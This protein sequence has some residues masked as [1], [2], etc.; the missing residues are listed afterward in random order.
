[1]ER[2]EQT[3]P[4]CNPIYVWS[5]QLILIQTAHQ[6]NWMRQSTK[7]VHSTMVLTMVYFPMLVLPIHSVSLQRCFHVRNIIYLLFGMY[8]INESWNMLWYIIVYT[9]KRRIVLM[10][11]FIPLKSFGGYCACCRHVFIQNKYY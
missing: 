8:S 11:G 5:I 2:L 6:S 4:A 10:I 1:M 9:C 3:L 7:S